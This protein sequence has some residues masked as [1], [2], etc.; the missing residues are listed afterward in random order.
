[1]FSM[2][3]LQQISQKFMACMTTAKLYITYQKM[4]PSDRPRL[5]YTSSN[6]SSVFFLFF[7]PIFLYLLVLLT[8]LV[9]PF[10]IPPSIFPVYTYCVLLHQ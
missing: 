4:S 1:M 9:L 3:Y 2:F 7:F 6:Q 8:G 10:K 5:A